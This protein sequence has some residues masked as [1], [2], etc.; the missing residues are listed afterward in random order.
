LAAPDAHCDAI[1]NLAHTF[2]AYQVLG[3]F[4]AVSEVAARRPCGAL[5]DLRTCL[6]FE[7]RRWR[8]YGEDPGAEA[9]RFIGGGVTRIRGH[10][11]G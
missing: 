3:S 9:E 6:F 7:G 11:G 5:D 10:L 2:R 4:D 1:L 8:R